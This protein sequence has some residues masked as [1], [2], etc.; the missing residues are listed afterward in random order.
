MRRIIHHSYPQFLCVI[1]PFKWL[2]KTFC[3]S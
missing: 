1:I 3:T 2:A